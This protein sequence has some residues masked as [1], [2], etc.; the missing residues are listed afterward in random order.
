MEEQVQMLVDLTGVLEV[1]VAVTVTEEQDP[2]ELEVQ[3]VPDYLHH[4][5]DH[6]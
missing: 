5:Q 4:I 3:E 1:V 2:P 6:H